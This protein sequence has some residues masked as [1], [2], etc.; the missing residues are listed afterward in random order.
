VREKLEMSR[1]NTREESPGGEGD[2]ATE[3][4]FNT[5]AV[6]DLTI[7]AGAI[8]RV[9]LSEA[10][11]RLGI[12]RIEEA[13][14]DIDYTA[15]PGSLIGHLVSA[16][17]T[18][19][20]SF[21]V[22]I[23]DATARN[24]L[25]E[26]IYPWTLEGGTRTVLHLK[27]TTDQSVHAMAT[28]IFA[29]GTYNLPLLSF[30]P[31][32]TIAIDIQALKH[33]KEPDAR[34]VP[35]AA[36]ATHGQFAWF[37]ETPYSLVGRAEQTNLS[38]GIARSF[39][40]D[41]I[42]CS[43]FQE[44][45]CAS[46]GGCAPNWQSFPPQN[47]SIPVSGLTGAVGSSGNLTGYQYGWDCNNRQF[48]PFTVSSPT[49]T[50]NSSV[51]SV[52]VSGHVSYVGAGSTSVGIQNYPV[53]T[54][55]FD[56]YCHCIGSSTGYT[57]V[58][59]EQAPVTVISISQSLPLWYF[60]NGVATPSGFTLGSKSA[61]LS[62][63]GATSGT[64]VWTIT[65]GTSKVTLENNS[66]TITKQ[67]TN[68]VGISSTSFSTQ[69]NDVTVQLKYTAPG[70]GSPTTFSWNLSVDSPY[71]LVSTGATTNRGVGGSCAVTAPNGTDGFQSLV[72]YKIISFSA[73]RLL[74]Y[75]LM[76]HLINPDRI[77]SQTIGGRSPRGLL[78]PPV[79]RSPTTYAS[80]VVVGTQCLC[81]HRR[82][83]QVRLS[84]KWGSR[85]GWVLR[86]RA[87]V[88]RYRRIRSFF[89]GIM[90]CTRELHRLF[91]EGAK[92][93]TAF[94]L[95]ALLLSGELLLAE[96]VPIPGTTPIK[97]VFDQ[98]DLVCN[99]FVRSVAVVGERTAEI[100]GRY[101]RR[102]MTKANVDIRDPYK[103]AQENSGIAVAYEQDLLLQAPP[104][105]SA[106]SPS[107]VLNVRG[108]RFRG[109]DA[110]RVAIVEYADFECPYCGEY[111]RTTF[112]KL[113][114][115]YIQT[116]K[117]RY[118][119]RDLPLPMHPLAV[120]AARAARCAGEQGKYWEMHDSLFAAQNA[121]STRALLD[122][123]PTL[124]LDAAKFA[125]CFSSDKYAEDLRKSISTAQALGIEGT[126]TFFI[127]AIDGD[128]VTIKKAIQG[129]P[130]FQV[131]K[132]NLA[133]LLASKDL[134]TVSPH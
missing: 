18:G 61:T 24:S 88:K 89:I 122:R 62:A 102:R 99:C 129:G 72:P 119:Y 25:I 37:P 90:L 96:I 58:S 97:Q 50:Y 67:N 22:P 23:K 91:F 36:E 68:T 48:G 82:H 38:E 118:F 75:P 7:P 65:N 8:A 6:K 84:S 116:G 63:N 77:L 39:S 29:G 42:C 123:A 40:C 9:E 128:T 54:Y 132:S 100:N 104:F 51:V 130:P 13:G 98:A 106:T 105:L 134:D 53:Q 19:D 125:E 101:V 60:G 92:M 70:G 15:A 2:G 59:N 86:L 95:L 27:N 115:E 76:K 12:D 56:Q 14:V 108:E 33:S 66:N 3:D 30:Q 20:Y 32:Q 52:N 103:L 81:P 55:D 11:E 43:N 111:E 131:F 121:L 69:S 87:S 21:E 1:W 47:A 57:T 71:K 124:G 34:G 74:T 126:P 10:L 41:T 73:L 5:M 117:V 114:S 16:D 4:K 79:E 127:G 133:A 45:I 49:W 46:T 109:D 93:R 94:Y 28:F 85:G 83:L 113:L 110:A 64:F 17:Q 120:S 31:Y 44:R 78:P 35:F 107:T 80:R 26:G 112:P